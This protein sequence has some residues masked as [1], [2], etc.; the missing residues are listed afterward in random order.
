MPGFNIAGLLPDNLHLYFHYNESLTTPPCHESIKWTVFNQ[1]VMLSKE[2]VCWPCA[3]WI[4]A[5][6]G[7]PH[8]TPLTL[9]SSQMS[10]LVSSLHTDDHRLLMNNFRQDQSLHRRWVLASFEPSSSRE[11]QV[12]AGKECVSILG[13][14][15]DA[16][17]LCFSW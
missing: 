17:E 5:P 3:C 12:P 15:S 2:Q 8:P 14:R 7:I 16:S 11:R 1:T 4:L 10:I 13:G 6:Q 9:L